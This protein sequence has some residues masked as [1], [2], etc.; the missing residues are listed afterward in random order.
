MTE[1][2]LATT[3]GVTVILMMVIAGTVSIG[4]A[5]HL[6]K[7]VAANTAAILNDDG[8][9]DDTNV[10]VDDNRSIESFVT[11]AAESRQ[12]IIWPEKSLVFLAVAVALVSVRGVFRLATQEEDTCN[13]NELC[14][15]SL[16]R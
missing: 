14:S 12:D 10:I 2:K 3:L 8:I 16:G 5:V 15:F 11:A 13:F 9:P 1:E 4:Y 7:L 6:R